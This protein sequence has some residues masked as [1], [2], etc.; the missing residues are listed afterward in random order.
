MALITDCA[1]LPTEIILLSQQELTL[2]WPIAKSL[3]CR[4]IETFSFRK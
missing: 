4:F 1:F 2:L 3:P